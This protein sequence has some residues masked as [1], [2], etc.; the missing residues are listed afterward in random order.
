MVVRKLS[1]LQIKKSN[2]KT[3]LEMDQT[4]GR[5]YTRPGLQAEKTS[6]PLIQKEY[7]DHGLSG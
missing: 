1:A 6:T 2:M 5:R 4:L 7:S 3:L